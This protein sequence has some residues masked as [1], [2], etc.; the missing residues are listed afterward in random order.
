MTPQD[1]AD[2]LVARQGQVDFR[3]H[4]VELRPNLTLETVIYL[5][6][7]VDVEKL[8]NARRAFGQA[9]TARQDGDHQPLDKRFLPH[10]GLRHFRL[11]LVVGCFQHSWSTL[12]VVTL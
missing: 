12:R 9:M 7:R 6:K 3:D 11:D 10:H 5:K 2:L 4:L 8:R 1:V